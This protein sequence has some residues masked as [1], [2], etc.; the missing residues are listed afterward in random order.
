MSLSGHS[1]LEPGHS[2]FSREFHR[3]AV[4]SG[5]FDSHSFLSSLEYNYHINTCRSKVSLDSTAFLYLISK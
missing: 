1:G 4:Y 5:R 3:K 2:E